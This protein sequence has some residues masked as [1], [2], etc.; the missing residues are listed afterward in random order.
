[1]N[2]VMRWKLFFAFLFL[3]TGLTFAGFLGV[4]PQ[5]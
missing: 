3:A 1:M 2:T 4:L 5:Q